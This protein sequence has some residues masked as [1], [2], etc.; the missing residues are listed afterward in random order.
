[1]VSREAKGGIKDQWV[2]GRLVGSVLRVNYS[3]ERGKEEIKDQWL[4]R[5]GSVLGI[6][7]SNRFTTGF[8]FGL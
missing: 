3:K 4:V 6:G 8:L 7:N 1:M 2:G 5:C